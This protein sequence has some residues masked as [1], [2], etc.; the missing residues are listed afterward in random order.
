LSVR[1]DPLAF[2]LHDQI[3]KLI[4]APVQL[5]TFK[6]ERSGAEHDCQGR[7]GDEDYYNQLRVLI[8]K[9]ERVLGHDVSKGGPGNRNEDE[10]R[11]EDRAGEL[12][13]L[14]APPEPKEPLFRN[15]HD[16]IEVRLDLPAGGSRRFGLRRIHLF[17][18]ERVRFP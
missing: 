9:G 6:E 2:H 7:D 13:L 18:E 5:A 4:E 1:R 12:H 11:R 10:H 17:Y 16:C 14:S 15:V 3:L 8:K